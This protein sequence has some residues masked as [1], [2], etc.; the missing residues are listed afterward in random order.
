MNEDGGWLVVLNPKNDASVAYAF[1]IFCAL[2]FRLRWW[3]VPTAAV[4]PARTSPENGTQVDS[5]GGGGH[6][7]TKEGKTIYYSSKSTDH[8]KSKLPY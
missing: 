7:M 8:R 2:S 1:E 3:L 5:F 4:L 6:P